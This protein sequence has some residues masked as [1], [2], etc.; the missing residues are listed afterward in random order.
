MKREFSLYLDLV[1]LFAAFLVVFYHSANIYNPGGFLFQLG[2]EAVV[3]F[4]VLSG[5][6][7]AFVVDT[8]EKSLKAYAVA[9]I[10][11]IYSVALPAILLTMLADQIGFAVNLEA[12]PPGWQAWDYPL[13]R[14]IGS[15]FFLNEFWFISI[16][17]F[18][19]IPYWSL[20]YEVWYYISFALL[21]YVQGTK[22]WILFFLVLLLL[23]PKILLL[24][25]LWWL[26]VYIYRSERLASISKPTAV[27]LLVVSTIGLISFVYFNIHKLGSDLLRG[28]LGVELH[29]QLAHSRWV[30]SDY[31]LALLIAAN[32]VAVRALAAELFAVLGRFSR[33]IRY[34]SSFTFA[35]YL[36]HQPLLLFFKALLTRGEVDGSSYVLIMVFTFLSMWALGHYTEHNRPAFKR[37]V[38]RILESQFWMNVPVVKNFLKDR[39][40]N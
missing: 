30:L 35:F 38:L 16:Q 14:L 12:Y 6:V 3:I 7:I 18:S 31:P 34:F 15:T 13:V 2:H 8:K 26:G 36:F 11:R 27:L 40:A 19:N 39:A 23:G 4:F 1:R 17:T 29:R 10:S 33:P 5:Y 22:K 20:N 21:V 25:P 24:M 37:L 9:R 32:F 28:L